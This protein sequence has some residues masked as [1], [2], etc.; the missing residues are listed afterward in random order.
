MRQSYIFTGRAAAPTG[1]P[2]VHAELAMGMGI[3][4][5]RK[6]VARLM[7]QAGLAGVCRRRRQGFTRRDPKQTPEPDRVQRHFSPEAP[8][9]LWVADMT[10]HATDEGWLYVAVVIDAFSRKVVG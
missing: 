5:S 10:Q 6:R 7:R 3:H 2:R 1:Y 4:C 8:D 9:R